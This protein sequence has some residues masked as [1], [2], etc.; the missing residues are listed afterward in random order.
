MKTTVEIPD[1]LYRSAKSKAAEMGVSFRSYLIDALHMRLN[2]EYESDSLEGI[3][4]A[5]AAEPEAVYAV[6]R[7]VEDDLEQI[8]PDEWR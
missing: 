7:V 4:G 3:F 5:F 8:D 2:R 6:E 1:E